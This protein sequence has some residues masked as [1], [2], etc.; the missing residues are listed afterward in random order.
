MKPAILKSF[1]GVR[2][3]IP[4][5]RFSP[6][7]LAVGEN[8]DLDKTGRAS[9]RLGTSLA[10]PGAAHSLWADGDDC[11][12][13]LDGVQQRV[14]PDR[15]LLPITGVAGARVAYVK[16]GADVFWSD[17][18]N[19]VAVRGSEPRQWGISPPPP[20]AAEAVGAGALRDGR[21]LYA[22][23]Y[24]RGDGKE[25][26]ASSFGVV[27]ASG[28][29]R[30]PAIPVSADPT[31]THKTIYLSA[32][33]GDLP[34]AAATLANS[35]TS[36]EVAEPPQK[37]LALRTAN[38]RAAPAGKVVGAYNG[39]AYV[40]QGRFLWFSL[41]LEYE[42]FNAI[43]GYVDLLD[44]IRTFAPVSDGIFVGTESRTLFL[45]GADPDAFVVRQVAKH[46]T[47]LGTEQRVPGFRVLDGSRQGVH[48]MWLSKS[49]VC[50]G[51][52]G[53]GFVE[54]TAGRYRPPSGAT[55]GASLL[56]IRGESAQL[57]TSLFS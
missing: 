34:Y 33:N 9:R 8:I 46:G 1:A 47:I 6:A 27:A 57:V 13:V 32:W 14:L 54:L 38:L 11:F 26:G 5:E 23:T 56:K 36:A 51:S 12:V 48:W 30:F 22:L 49:G 40:A 28:G 44:D 42:L 19:S 39:R 41:P 50:L 35:V 3:D 31:V 4:I 43:S 52:D 24:S 17:G 29:V 25:S 45:S 21:Y 37:A 18:I 55:E 16:I 20:M 2:N 53:G 10:A 7:D 15:S